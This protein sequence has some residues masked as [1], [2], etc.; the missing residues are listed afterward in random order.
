MKILTVFFLC[1]CFSST[2]EHS[3]EF[4]VTSSHGFPHFPEF[5]VVVV[6]DGVESGS[7]DSNTRMLKLHDWTTE[8]I[9]DNPDYLQLFSQECYGTEISFRRYT[10]D[11]MHNLNQNEGVHVLQL[12]SGCEWDEETGETAG[13]LKLGYDGE[14]FMALDLQTST[15]TALKPEAN[16]TKLR[17][18]ADK[19]GLHDY[20]SFYKY[21]CS[22]WLKEFLPYGRKYLQRTVLPSVSLLQK[23]PSSPVSCF[24]TGF[25]PDR[26]AMFWRKDGEELYEGVDHGEILPNNDDTF[27]M[28]ADLNISSVKLEDWEKYECVFQLSG[29]KEDIVT[30]LD[31]SM[32]PY[33]SPPRVPVVI[34]V[35]AGLLLLS[36][37]ITG[38]IMW[39]KKKNGEQGNAEMALDSSM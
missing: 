35:V 17:W 23:S 28:S 12:R 39:R 15:W 34:G 19:V 21:Q 24:A 13:F 8:F 7:Y 10:V 4:C 16:I 38:F 27:Q 2:V 31:K 29:V 3:L 33:G 32:I 18:D 36:V 20:T 14:D 22:I 37:C 1:C 11:I 6:V 5:V 30:R 26:A 9:R 25:Y